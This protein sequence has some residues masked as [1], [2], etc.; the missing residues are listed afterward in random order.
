[1]ADQHRCEPK[2]IETEAIEPVDFE[3]R[4]VELD[5]NLGADPYQIQ[6]RFMR[7][8]ITE[9]MWLNFGKVGAEKSYIQSQM[10]FDYDSAENT[11]DSDLEEEER[12]KM[13]ASPLCMQS[14]EDCK[15]ISNTNCIGITCCIV[16][17]WKISSKVR[18]SNMLIRQKWEDL[19]LKA[20]KIICSVRPDLNV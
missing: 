8:C 17:I 3:P 18:C 19:I 1:M 16:L 14:Q 15:I 5:R 2:L 13:L 10:H 9:D 12:R 4:R 20:I 7:H 11:A 6:E